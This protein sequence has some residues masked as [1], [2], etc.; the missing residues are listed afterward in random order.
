MLG[1]D[2]VA[3]G[4]L[5]DAVAVLRH[6]ITIAGDPADLPRV[7]AGLHMALGETL[8]QL[9]DLA[10]AER[11]HRAAL[12]LADR[13]LPTGVLTEQILFNLASVENKR[14]DDKDAEVAI[15][16]ALQI[17]RAV[18]P[19]ASD[20]DDYMG[21]TSLLH[22]KSQI[23]LGLGNSAAAVTTAKEALEAGQREQIDSDMYGTVHNDLA[24]ALWANGQRDLARQAMHQAALDYQ[25]AGDVAMQLG[26][27]GL[28]ALSE[29]VSASCRARRT[30][31]ACRARRRQL[32]VNAKLAALWQGVSVTTC[33]VGSPG[34]RCGA[35]RDSSIEFAVN[36]GV[37][38][39]VSC[40]TSVPSSL[41]P[42]C[43]LL[44]AAVTTLPHAGRPALSI[45]HSS[46]NDFSAQVNRPML[47]V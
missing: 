11:E 19:G 47:H 16:R 38:L 31:A 30:A 1:Q 18:P 34:S 26:S 46:A 8:R 3:L 23:Q 33:F 44:R 21:E 28:A 42:V 36:V 32:P 24:R 5:D 12:E 13:A 14:G 40:T 43:A 41:P 9:G 35:L 25:L 7:V 37:Q 2:L 10:N 20:A 29:V 4:Q 17:V 27:R 6:A 15:E 45:L 39:N 22:K